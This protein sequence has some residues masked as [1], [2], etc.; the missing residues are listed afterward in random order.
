MQFTRFT[1][2]SHRFA[3]VGMASLCVVLSGCATKKAE[4]AEADANAVKG[5]QIVKP[6]GVEKLFGFISPYR[7]SIQQGN[8]VSQE[9]V[10]Q[11]KEGMTREQ[12]RFLLGTALLTDMF[13]EDRWD[14]PFRM[15]KPNGEVIS[16]RLAIFFKDNTV[17]RFEG[18]NLP[19]EKE[20]LAHIT[21]SAITSRNESMPTE[22][23]PKKK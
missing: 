10:S 23:A 8:F 12:V 20:Y 19:T 7:I 13:H 16:S 18:G 22:E 11:L 14:Y 1:K 5:T 21:S 15:L 2:I 17:A 3:L 4:I 9:M 6:T